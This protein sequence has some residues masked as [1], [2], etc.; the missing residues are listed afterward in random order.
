MAFIARQTDF[1]TAIAPYSP[2]A[3][4]QHGFW[5]RLF[6]SVMDGRQR[7]TQREVER[8]VAWHGR[9]MTDALEREIDTRLF[10]NGWSIH[11]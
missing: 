3:Q 6:D 10:R 7:R 5:R 2:P 4:P 9:G 8:F 11:R 1:H